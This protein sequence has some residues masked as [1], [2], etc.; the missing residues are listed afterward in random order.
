MS[1]PDDNPKTALGIKKPAMDTIPSVA[2]VE[3][4]VRMGHGAD[5]YGS[6]NWRHENIS[7]SVYVAAARRHLAAFVDGEYIDPDCP[8]DT[9]HLSAVM[10]CC[11][12]LID[13]FHIGN[14]NDNRPPPAPT[15]AVI[16]YFEEHGKM[17]D[18]LE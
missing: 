8:Y 3:L 12:L 13:G 11:A 15:G 9:S 16:R 10:A 18:P 14:I 1:Y 5:K 4:G 2:L 7:S 6:F 17:P